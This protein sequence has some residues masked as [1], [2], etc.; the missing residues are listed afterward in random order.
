[1]RYSLESAGHW[2]H[3]LSDIQNPK[4]ASIILKKEDFEDDVK[5]ECQKNV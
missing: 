4:S 5:L 3:T 1:M 2:D